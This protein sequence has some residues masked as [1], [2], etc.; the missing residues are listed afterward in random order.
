M[1]L[2]NENLDNPGIFVRI[3]DEDDFE[4]FWLDGHRV[5]EITEGE[6]EAGGESITGYLQRNQ[7]ENFSREMYSP[8]GE[9]EGV[10]V[11]RQLTLYEAVHYLGRR[12]DICAFLR[13]KVQAERF[14]HGLEKSKNRTYREAALEIRHYLHRFDEESEEQLT[15]TGLFRQMEEQLMNIS[16]Q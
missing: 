11:L 4:V 6:Q 2:S 12:A 8:L 3:F 15:R 13:P 14:I 1:S 5:I 7:V 16:V 9:Y 10:A